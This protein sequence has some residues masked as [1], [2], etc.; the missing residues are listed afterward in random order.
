MLNTLTIED[1]NLIRRYINAFAGRDGYDSSTSCEDVDYVLRF[2]ERN[3]QDLFEAFGEQFILTRKFSFT[4]GEGW[5]NDTIDEYLFNC[6]AKGRAFISNF[7]NWMGSTYGNYWRYNYHSEI[8]KNQYDAYHGLQKLLSYDC[9]AN[10]Q[11][12]GETFKIP[13]P[14]SKHPIVVSTGC[15]VSKILGKIA[16]AYN[17]PKYEEF[18][19]AHSLC[20]NTKKLSGD[21]CLSIH[22]LDYMTMSDNDCNW[23]S[24]MS[25]RDGGEF[26]QGTVEMMNS[27]YI[28][29]AYMK[30]P[31]DFRFFPYGN[32]DAKWNNKRWRT[33]F[34]VHHNVI[35]GIRQYPY[36]SQELNEFC[37][38]WLREVVEPTGKYGP[39]S[40][41]I[42]MI[43]NH[44][45][46]NF[47]NEVNPCHMT[48]QTNRMYNDCYNEHAAYVAKHMPD[49]LSI[50]YSGETECVVCGKEFDCDDNYNLP[51]S[52][53]TCSRHS[54]FSRCSC[55]DRTIYNEEDDGYWIGDDLICYDC[56]ENK[57]ERCDTCGDMDLIDNMTKYYIKNNNIYYKTSTYVCNYCETYHRKSYFGSAT[58]IENPC[59]WYIDVN[60][61]SVKGLNTLDL[62]QDN[63]NQDIED[64]CWEIDQDL[65][66]TAAD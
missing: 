63:F 4:K 41:Y 60:N 9:L 2:W 17:I 18:R 65:S 33:L 19:I 36:D 13:D 45:T 55:C 11:Y 32:D 30:D 3:K 5:L 7:Q 37:L 31:E 53:L 54:D 6:G 8:Y 16:L 44:A 14:K 34:I 29:V 59:R 21:V 50:T 12:D 61:F 1:K 47:H 43:T 46:N 57:C 62:T 24:C 22:P 58:L 51:T 23:N 64:E 40:D 52:S 27:P 49:R 66:D 38:K 20:L 42:E 28:V 35:M 26:R 15:K 48:F 39:Y 25:W 56:Y 10:N